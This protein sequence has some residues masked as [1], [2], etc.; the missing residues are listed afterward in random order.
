M[1]KAMFVIVMMLPCMIYFT[2]CKKHKAENATEE[3]HKVCVSDT[4]RN[5]ISIDTAKL[6]NINDELVLSG[7]VSFDDNKV[8]KIFPF[9]QRTSTRCES[10]L[11]R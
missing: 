6:S 5:M 11:G 8:V 10:G 7:E 4:M 9:A 1:K 2:S 3:T